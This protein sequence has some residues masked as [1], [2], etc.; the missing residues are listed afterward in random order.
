[1]S[2]KNGKAYGGHLVEGTIVL[3]TAD[4]VIGEITGIEMR[5]EYDP[6]MEVFLLSPK[7]L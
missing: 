2:D 5:R 7:Q 6:E 3:M 1:M 4:I